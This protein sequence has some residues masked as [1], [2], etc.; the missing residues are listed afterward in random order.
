MSATSVK[1]YGNDMALDV[2]ADFC[3][4]YG[5]GKTVDEI[6]DYIFA[7]QPDDDD[8]EACAFWSALA[9]IEWEY[10]VL[11]DYVRNKAQYIIANHSDA[12]L[13]LKKKDEEARAIELQKLY[14]QISTINPTPKKRKKTFVYRTEWK[15]GDVFAIPLCS[16]YVYIH[17][18]AI[19]RPSQKIEELAEDCVFIRVFDRI[20]DKVLGIEDFKPKIFRK[21]QYKNLDKFKVCPVKWLWCVG[22]REK[23]ELE[24]KVI[25]IGN[26]PTKRETTGNVYADFQFSKLENTLCEMFGLS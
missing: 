2:K 17:I 20:S 5:I 13:F 4:L 12:S 22:N 19:E 8:E 26:S 7:Y 16:K 21:I 25:Y 18:C 15:E 14:E 23:T 10:G 24:K 9:L 3:N 1:I 6:N 11:T